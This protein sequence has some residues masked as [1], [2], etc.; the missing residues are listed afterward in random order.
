VQVQFP[1]LS[2]L[3]FLL[4]RLQSFFSSVLINPNVDQ[5]QGWFSFE[6]VPLKWQHP[7]GLLYDTLSGSNP[8]IAPNDDDEAAIP[9]PTELP[10][11]L[12]LHFTDFPTDVLLPLDPFGKVHHDAYI[13]S[14]KEADFLRNGTAKVMMSLS[15]DDSTEL[16]RSVQEHDLVLFNSINQK[17]L[18]PPPGSELRHVPIKI[19]LPSAALSTSD[20]GNEPRMGTLKVVQ[21]LVTPCFETGKPQTLGSTLNTILPTVFPS[22]RSYIFAHAVLHGAVLPLAAH[23]QELMRAAAYADGF[24]HIAVV[25]VG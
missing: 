4:P 17:F 18:N 20:A 10:W 16:W 6:G 12:I 5:S 22:K 23:V 21:S 7:L 3:P 11:K 14:V 9:P 1:R 19:Y 2:Y 15:K 13:N 24:L 8:A 25:L